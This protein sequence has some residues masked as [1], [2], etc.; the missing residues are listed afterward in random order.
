MT[1]SND[2][3][4]TAPSSRRPIYVVSDSTGST[5][6]SVVRAAMIQFG[7]HRPPLRM[8]PRVRTRKEVTEVVTA[9]AEADALIV[10]TLVNPRLRDHLYGAAAAQDVR[11]VDLL[12]ALLGTLSEYLG[13]EPQGRPGKQFRLDELYFERVAAMEFSVKADD[14]Q[15][16]ALWMKADIVLVGVSRTSKTPVSSHLAQAGYRVANVPIVGGIEP[17]AELQ[18]LPPG[19]VFALTIDPAK[20]M[21]IR[22]S[23][24]AHLGVQA[25]GMYADREHVFDE[26][27]WALRYYRRHTNW[28][29]ID[30]TTMA[31]E[32]TAAEILKLRAKLL[33]GAAEGS[34]TSSR[35]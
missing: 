21:E 1:D 12:G 20:L 2:S 8:R 34:S 6:E 9:A 25:R 17:P 27:R 11:S 4:S 28:P 14:G 29:V 18:S 26:V 10:H 22:Q 31:V 3:S 7:D 33:P 5:A 23:R 19:H 13:A 35:G 30:V 24:L 32:E 15:D 16:P